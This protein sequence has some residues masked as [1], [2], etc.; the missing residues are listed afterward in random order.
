MTEDRT[1]LVKHE[2]R[3][4]AYC[5]NSDFD[6]IEICVNEEK[7]DHFRIKLE[8][9]ERYRSVKDA[10]AYHDWIIEQIRLIKT[11]YADQWKKQK[12][13]RRKE[14][15]KNFRRLKAAEADFSKAVLDFSIPNIAD[16]LAKLQ[17]GKRKEQKRL[18]R[19]SLDS[20]S[21][22]MNLK[23]PESVFKKAKELH[24]DTMKGGL[25]NGQN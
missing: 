20:L 2:S 25:I 14:R 4:F 1:K 19:S 22:A 23:I 3:F 9:P 21:K 6:S 18:R 16:D 13:K 7:P 8:P 11:Q 17:S 5:P 10:I 12:R 15:K 24:V